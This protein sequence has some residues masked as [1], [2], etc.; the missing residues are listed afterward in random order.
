MALVVGIGLNVHMT[1]LHDEIST[2][3]TSMALL[4]SR[5][6]DRELLLA[7]ILS[8][9]ERRAIDYERH[10]LTAI[11]DELREHDAIWGKSVRVGDKTG[12]ARGITDQGA[13]L[14]DQGGSGG[15]VEL[16]SGLVQVLESP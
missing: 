9:L 7:D 1:E 5:C 4:G 3:A 8:A 2:I 15:L 12:I 6:L 14:L 16:T 11:L 10:G 13:L